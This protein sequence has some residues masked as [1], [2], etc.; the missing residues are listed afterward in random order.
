ML[1]TPVLTRHRPATVPR[2]VL[3]SRLF[4]PVDVASL[5]CFRFAFGLIM[6]WEVGRYFAYDWIRDYYIDPTFYFSYYGFDWVRPWPG[7]GMYLHF[8]AL[9]VL[10]VCIAVGFQYR[11][12]ITLFFVGFTYVLLLDESRWLNHFYLVSLVSFLLIFVP[13]HR[14]FSVDSLLRPQ[15]RSDTAPAWSLWILRAQLALVYLFGAV[16]KL[17]P[18]WL[19]GEPM[20]MW[21]A[22]RTD[23]PLIGPLLTQPLAA[24]FFSY[25]GLLFDLLFVPLVL[26]RRTRPVALAVAVMFHLL[27]SRLF[28]IG[29]FPWFMLAANLLFLSPGWPRVLLRL[30]RVDTSSVVYA[31]RPKQRMIIAG[32]AIFFTVQ[33]LVP[34][35]RYRYPGDVNWTQQGDRFAWRMKLL[36][37]QGEAQFFATDPVSG[38]T[39]E[40]D[41]LDFITQRQLREM[42]IRPDMT[43][44]LA[45]HIADTLR[46]QG[47]PQ[48]Q[49]RAQVL[50]SLNGRDLQDQIDPTVDLAAQ[51]RTLAPA[52]WIMPAPP[53]LPD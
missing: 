35:R 28:D 37:V 52:N 7:I 22:D 2:S 42:V 30:P 53:P 5:A 19:H 8:A 3:V 43:L 15:I 10:A 46:A 27:N 38:Q 4:A 25:G 49:V 21:L 16:A 48:I 44:Q 33:L 47:Y 34:L 13:A 26:W 6:L 31:I 40:V 9:G 24:Y 36:D 29:I 50:V 1:E 23:F 41:P 14:A 11:V 39:W 17:N 18:D 51:P 12:S 20:R 45:H 32:I